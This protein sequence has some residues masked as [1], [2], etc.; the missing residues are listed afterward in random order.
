MKKQ[1]LPDPEI[2]KRKLILKDKIIEIRNIRTRY[3]CLTK[4]LYKNQYYLN[5]IHS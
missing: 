5:E 4:K 3:Y 1:D 2:K